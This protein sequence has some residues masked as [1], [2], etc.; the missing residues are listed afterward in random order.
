VNLP[1]LWVIANNRKTGAIPSA[2]VGDTVEG[3]WKSCEGCALRDDRTCYAWTGL[4]GMRFK[5]AVVPGAKKD[6]KRYTLSAVLA[7]LKDVVYAARIG[8]LGD[9]SR[10]RRSELRTAIAHLRRRGIAV[11]GYTHFWRDPANQD[12]RGDLMASC[13]SP[14]QADEAL[15]LGWRPATV[16]PWWHVGP[17]FLT[18]EGAPGVVC[19]AQ[20]KEKVTCESCRMCDPQHAVWDA[21]RAKVIGF[22]DHSSRG[23]ASARKAESEATMS[24]FPPDRFRV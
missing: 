17:R 2:Y 10:A 7:R 24:L 13:D 22:V 6:P 12:L 1:L 14:E 19:P 23:R 15:A 16:L 20:T 18:P 9:P 21:G 11:L 3:A 4:N 8:V 5:G